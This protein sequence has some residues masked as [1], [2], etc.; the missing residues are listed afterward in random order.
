MGGFTGE[1]IL[2]LFFVSGLKYVPHGMGV[3]S[4]P[5]GDIFWFSLNWYGSQAFHDWG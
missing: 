3:V 1:E 4:H 2:L 5:S